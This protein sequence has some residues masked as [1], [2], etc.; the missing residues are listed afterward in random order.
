M[1][2]VINRRRAIT[3]VVSLAVVASPA[4]A[5]FPGLLARSLLG[6]IG[7]T[8]GASSMRV[9]AAAVGAATRSR[10]A[11][12]AGLIA[13]RSG[14]VARETI[15]NTYGRS[16]ANGMGQEM[17]QAAGRA[18]IGALGSG[19][20]EVRGRGRPRPNATEDDD[21]FVA[22]PNE[23]HERSPVLGCPEISIMGSIVDLM[24]GAFVRQ[25]AA[26]NAH[27]ATIMAFPL[28]GLEVPRY[29][30]AW[31]S[32]TPTVYESENHIVRF[33]ASGM[34]TERSHVRLTIWRN[35]NFGAAAAVP[36]TSRVPELDQRVP[37]IE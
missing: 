33:T 8:A 6:F 34:M 31:N 23:G 32:Q 21:V 37:I 17:G 9:G 18:V 2:T 5:F 13:R 12:A 27:T 16:F 15:F 3:G 11:S 10:A 19:W 35:S 20:G 29:D 25:S 1:Q 14:V 22:F 30:D 4:Q 7:R 26:L 24:M 36:L 28:I